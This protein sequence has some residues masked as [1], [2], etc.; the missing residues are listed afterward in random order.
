MLEIW[1]TNDEL[2]SSNIGLESVHFLDLMVDP[3]GATV[4]FTSA[5]ALVPSTGPTSSKPNSYA[6]TPLITG[7]TPM[8]QVAS[9]LDSNNARSLP[10]DHTSE[11]SSPLSPVPIKRYPDIHACQVRDCNKR[12]TQQR[13]LLEVNWSAIYAMTCYGK[14]Y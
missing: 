13:Q 12:F 3:Q 7:V 2:E 8:T 14:C 6:S 4:P 10:S 5:T 1:F 11:C 9:P